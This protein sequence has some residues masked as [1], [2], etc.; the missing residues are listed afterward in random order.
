MKQDMQHV[1]F[2]D[3]IHAALDQ[4]QHGGGSVMIWARIF[5]NKIIGL[6]NVPELVK[7]ISVTNCEVCL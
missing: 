4:R 7:I 2:S 6:V 3:E 1:A 5:D